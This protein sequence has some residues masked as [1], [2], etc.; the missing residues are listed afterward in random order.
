MHFAGQ[1]AIDYSKPW[2]VNFFSGLNGELTAADWV[3]ECLA[4]PEFNLS[5]GLYYFYTILTDLVY[6]FMGQP[7]KISNSAYKEQLQQLVAR[8]SVFRTMDLLKSLNQLL[9]SVIPIKQ[10]NASIVLEAYCLKLWEL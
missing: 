7:D 4:D 2:A 9:R 3:K 10:L 1:V 5:D 8:T 6:L